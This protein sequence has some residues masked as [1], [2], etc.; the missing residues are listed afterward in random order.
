[1]K[2]GLLLVLPITSILF[3]GCATQSDSPANKPLADIDLFTFSPVYRN[4]GGYIIGGSPGCVTGA[5]PIKV[6]VTNKKSG[7]RWENLINEDGSFSF[8]IQASAGDKIKYVFTDS[9]GRRA[10]KTLR[11]PVMVRGTLSGEPPDTVDRFGETPGGP[12]A[13]LKK[14]RMQSEAAQQQSTV[15]SHVVY[16]GKSLSPAM[17]IENINKAIADEYADMRWQA[18]CMAR[19]KYP[20]DV[21]N[22]KLLFSQ[23][24][25][26]AKDH[27][28]NKYHVPQDRIDILY[29]R[30]WFV[31]QLEEP[32][33]K[34]VPAKMALHSTQSNDRGKPHQD[35]NNFEQLLRDIG[36]IPSLI[37]KVE[38]WNV[39][40]ELINDEVPQ[41]VVN[42]AW[43]YEPYQLRLQVAQNLWKIWAGIHSPNNPG[44]SWIRIVDYNGNEVGGSK[45][46]SWSSIIFGSGGDGSSIWVKE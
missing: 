44:H 12:K 37:V 8:S 27:L 5:C 29:Q 19:E 26:S 25:D 41:I 13:L 10:S 28:C 18:I 23:M 34:P 35:M 21:Y 7:D 42:N 45:V 36:V 6:V 31:A 22:R 39:D 30:Y 43:H 16:T 11:I 2:Y 38:P 20:N 17:K 9:A 4:V 3:C 14:A 40:G 46:P 33:P 32:T 1:M 24:N 15:A